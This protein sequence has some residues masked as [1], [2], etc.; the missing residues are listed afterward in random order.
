MNLLLKISY[1]SLLDN[2]RF[3]CTMQKYIPLSKKCKEKREVY[4]NN[5][6]LG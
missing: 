3:A 6:A 1:F 2:K 4:P 5:A